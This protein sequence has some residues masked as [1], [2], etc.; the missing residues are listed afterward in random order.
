MRRFTKVAA[1][2]ATPRPLTALIATGSAASAA[3]TVNPDGSGFVGKGD[4]QS[5]LG[6]NNKQMQ[7]STE[8]KGFKWTQKME[9]QYV[10][11]WTTSDG[12][13]HHVYVSATNTRQMAAAVARTNSNGRTAR[14]P[15]GT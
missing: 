7:E 14:S 5:V 10:W 1:I 11:D 3:V 9:W 6:Y 15:A 13:P 12:V 4:V 2:A 8:A